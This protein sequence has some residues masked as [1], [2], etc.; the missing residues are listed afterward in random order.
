MQDKFLVERLYSLKQIMYDL[1]KLY[2]II[3][4]P[5]D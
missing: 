1:T 3:N 2:I 4:S 5:F